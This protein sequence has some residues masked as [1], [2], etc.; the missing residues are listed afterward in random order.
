MEGTIPAMLILFLIL[1]VCYSLMHCVPRQDANRQLQRFVA[2]ILSL[3][4]ELN[5]CQDAPL[6]SENA[7]FLLLRLGGAMRHMQPLF[8]ALSLDKLKLKLLVGNLP[9]QQGSFMD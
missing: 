3:L 8:V 6:D 2:S 4:Q 1:F 9:P 5:R 7:E